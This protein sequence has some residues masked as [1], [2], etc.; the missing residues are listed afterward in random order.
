MPGGNASHK[1]HS[2]K[3]NTNANHLVDVA[4]ELEEDPRDELKEPEG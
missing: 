1:G 4:A 3:P 2:V